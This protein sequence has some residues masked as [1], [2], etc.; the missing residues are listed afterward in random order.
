MNA[1]VGK[2]RWVAF[3]VALSLSFLNCS[4]AG[5]LTPCKKWEPKRKCEVIK[6]VAEQ[7]PASPHSYIVEAYCDKNKLGSVFKANIEWA[8]EPCKDEYR[9]DSTNL[10]VGERVEDLFKNL[11]LEGFFGCKLYRKTHPLKGW[12]LAKA[13]LP[14]KRGENI[15]G[16]LCSCLKEFEKR[17]QEALNS[18]KDWKSFY[19]EGE[20]RIEVVIS[21]P[22]AMSVPPKDPEPP[23]S[24]AVK[25]NKLEE[26]EEVLDHRR[27]ITDSNPA[28]MPANKKDGQSA[29]GKT[30]HPKSRKLFFV[31]FAL[32]VL[33]LVAIVIFLIVYN[34]YNYN[35]RH[36]SRGNRWDESNRQM[37]GLQRH[38]ED[39]MRY[40]GDKIRI[41]NNR[42]EKEIKQLE[43][44][45]NDLEKNM[46]ARI[47]QM[48]KNKKKFEEAIIALY[49]TIP[50]EIWELLK[51]EDEAMK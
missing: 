6:F 11:G 17:L 35:S 18:G 39:K 42:L 2:K 16:C 34:Y 49:E 47:E 13:L 23:S 4:E 26:K 21:S 1:R 25:W 7:D 36:F 24:S 27:S 51:E 45:I 19:E 43:T 28:G 10:Q 37:K 41:T 50:K 15:A 40:L 20:R 3:V 9:V 44:A 8:A 33:S 46:R 31:V 14:R 22:N 32:V 38:L 5:A 30:S 29:T 12:K 48:E